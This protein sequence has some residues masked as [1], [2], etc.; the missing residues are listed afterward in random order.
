VFIRHYVLVNSA[1]KQKGQRATT[2]QSPLLV[3]KNANVEFFSACQV[4]S[5]DNP[6]GESPMVAD[7]ISDLAHGLGF[8]YLAATNGFALSTTSG[9]ALTGASIFRCEENE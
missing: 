4:K 2:Y 3:V 6:T 5:Q 7:K 1:I 9:N 8:P